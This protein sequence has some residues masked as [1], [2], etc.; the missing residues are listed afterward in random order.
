MVGPGT[1]S[2]EAFLASWC[3]GGGCGVET[4]VQAESSP[5]H[6]PEFPSGIHRS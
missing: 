3:W 1:A 5:S 6:W 2:S 4:S